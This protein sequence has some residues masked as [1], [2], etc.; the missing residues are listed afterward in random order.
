MATELEQA[1]A[2]ALTALELPGDE[3]KQRI[4]ATAVATLPAARPDR[5]PARSLP[6]WLQRRRSARS[7]RSRWRR[8]GP[9]ALA[10]VLA[11]GGA[12]LATLVL[13]GGSSNPRVGDFTSATALANFQ[14]NPALA[15]APWLNGVDGWETIPVDADIR[16]SLQ[17]PPGLN[18]PEALQRFY[19]A[20]SRHGTLPAG[21]RLGP[22]LP[23]GIVVSVPADAR[24]GIAIDLRAPFGYDIPYGLILGPSYVGTAGTSPAPG[25]SGAGPANGTRLPTGVRVIAPT[26]QACQIQH[27]P[28]PAHPCRL[29]APDLGTPRAGR[30]KIA[31]PDFGGQDVQAAAPL[32]VR[33][34]LELHPGWMLHAWTP[35]A[36]SRAQLPP[37]DGTNIATNRLGVMLYTLAQFSAEGA[38]ALAPAIEQPDCWAATRLDPQR[39]VAPGT[40]VAQYPPAGAV[41]P[42]GTRMLLA[43]A[44][45]DC[46]DAG[47]VGNEWCIP[48]AAARWTHNPRLATLPWL[49]TRETKIRRLTHSPS[50]HF[51]RDTTYLQAVRALLAAVLTEGRLPVGARL[52]PPLPR[53]VVLE[54]FPDGTLAIN[55]DAPFGY[56][57]ETGQVTQ[58]DQALNNAGPNLAFADARA[59]A[60]RR[61]QIATL[62]FTLALLTGAHL[63]P[64]KLPVC[65]TL[66]NTTGL[67]PGA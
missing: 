58:L 24:Q 29:F 43:V 51:A 35:A 57:P 12:A 60:I 50:L 27:P 4:R 19:D 45:D 20:I 61:G 59:R 36:I 23:T 46:L 44:S 22:P 55:L 5:R 39:A 33:S 8:Y 67:C 25:P 56:D 17:F 10:A 42:W 38:A 2:H 63:A 48:G 66:P 18:Y 54:R 47:L 41:V 11:V 30:G 13:Q 21:T 40:V 32:A 3:V 62:P 34:G 9:L 28:H 26:L 64:P 14:A 6:A 1:I 49:G 16:P 37:C 65:E 15:N 53:G 31:V 52:G 7:D